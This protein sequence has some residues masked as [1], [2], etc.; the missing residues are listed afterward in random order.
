MI[1]EESILTIIIPTYNRKE[2]LLNLLNSIFQEKVGNYRIIICDNCSTYDINDFLKQNICENNL[3]KIEIQRRI[4]NTGMIG[5]LTYAMT[6][7][8][9]K[10]FWTISDD[11]EIV[12]GALQKIYK[13]MENNKD[14]ALIKFSTLGI[15]KS[16]EEEN[17]EVSSLEQFI[18]YYYNNK[19]RDRSGNL[20][21][22]SN[23]VFNMEKIKDY[24]IFS[25]EYSY[26]QVPHMIPILMGLNEKKMKVKFSMKKVIKYLPPD[27]DHWNVGKIVLGASTFSHLPLNLTEDY[28]KK[29]LEIMMWVNYKSCILSLIKNGEKDS[30]RVFNQIYKGVYK[31]Y[32]PIKDK[33]IAILFCYILGGKKSFLLLKLKEML[34][35][36]FRGVTKIVKE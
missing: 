24:L 7:S 10:W 2:R 31:E 4:V 28:R 1:N 3:E 17:I 35:N 22:F 34:K 33:I 8:K 21:F 6:L 32:L 23:N 30:K 14:I 11:D 29:F 12:E 19:N 36:F 5:N 26:T 18:D 20:V 27:G 16:G 13:E 25:F 15:G 9:T